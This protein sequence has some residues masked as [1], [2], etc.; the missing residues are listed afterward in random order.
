M[1][2]NGNRKRI[3]TTLG[4]LIVA[5]SDAAFDICSDKKEA[6]AVVATALKDLLRPRSL[7]I[8]GRV[9]KFRQSPV[10]AAI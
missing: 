2:R 6:Y 1:R 10:A 9:R 4:D 7:K 5:L 3:D 8:N